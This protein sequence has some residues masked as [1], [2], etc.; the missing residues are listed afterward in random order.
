MAYECRIGFDGRLTNPVLLDHSSAVLYFD[1]IGLT[2]YH[3]GWDA[4]ATVVLPPVG[5]P[6]IQGS[7]RR[8]HDDI[9]WRRDR[10]QYALSGTPLY[11]DF[12][13]YCR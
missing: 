6:S 2:G 1:H 13:Y 12:E 10:D 5:T 7:Y 8:G 9:V 11:R 4:Y 3:N